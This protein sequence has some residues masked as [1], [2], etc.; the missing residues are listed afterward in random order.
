MVY[1]HIDRT[2]RFLQ[3][4]GFD[5]ILNKPIQVNIDGETED[6][7]FYDPLDQSLT[8]GTGGVDDAED[9][10]IILHEYGHAVQ[11]AMVPGFG[12]S[13]EA[14]A[15]GEG[16]GDYLA[17]SFFADRKPELVQVTMG[18]WDAVAYS[19]EEPPNLRRL[20]SNKKYPRDF[21]GEEHSDGEIWS[22][23][24]WQIRQALGAQTANRLIIA[25]HSL[26]PPDATFEQAAKQLIMTDKQLNGGHNGDAIRHNFVQRG[27][28][29]NPNRKNKRAGL[30]YND[31]SSHNKLKGK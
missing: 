2:Q 4:L 22:A 24:L 13:K 21:V 9:A 29:P 28:L 14:R 16:F 18:N 19:G 7:S 20:D 10:E 12:T 5:N 27:I 17:A 26:L 31:I 6:N 25:H 8:F 30:K 3:N 15:M 11:D 1:F 23:C